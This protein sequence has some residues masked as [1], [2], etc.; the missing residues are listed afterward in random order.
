[1]TSWTRWSIAE[2]SGKIEEYHRGL[3]LCCG[4][5]RAQ[6]RRARVQRNHIGLALRACL[7]LEHYCYTTG[8][9][10]FTTKVDIVR[11][12]V[13]AYLAN[14]DTHCQYPRNSDRYWI[15]ENA[16][17]SNGGPFITEIVLRR[18]VDPNTVQELLDSVP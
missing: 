13:R 11:E 15:R 7:R 2:A 4:V 8:I 5:E 12:A 17:S 9:S 16:L 10:W 3:Q 6:V 18:G 1:M 14:H